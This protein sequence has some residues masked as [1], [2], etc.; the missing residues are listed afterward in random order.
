MMRL[1]ELR[2]ERFGQ[3]TDK[4]F[5]FGDGSRGSDFHIIY[6]P[7]EAGKT[8]TMEA[9]IRLLYGFRHQEP[10]DF[11]HGRS[12]LRVSGV[13]DLAEGPLRL[14]RLPKRAPN[15]LDATGNA[16]PDHA[17][18][19][20]LGGLSE[21]DYRALLCLDDDT[22]ERGG[23]D[24]A[25]AR[26]DIGQLLFSAAAGIADMSD[27][28]TEL[29]ER[30]D[31]LFRKR[32]STTRLAELKR[33]LAEIDGQIR[34]QD[35]SAS[36]W[37]TL[38]DHLSAAVENE[39]SAREERDRLRRELEQA[40]AL[41]RAL[42]WLVEHDRL[43]GEVAPFADYPDQLDIE[44]ESLVQLEKEQAQLEAKRDRLQKEIAT[45]QTELEELH[46]D[47]TKLELGALLDALDEL[48]SRT[49]TAAIDLPKRRRELK[50]V[51][52]E[53]SGCLREL[54]LPP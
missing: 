6:G 26:G 43:V 14:S 3:F 52:D 15:L 53:I 35:V 16:L 45:A 22:I 11:L 23:E 12:N 32:A 38:K 25:N 33:E 19:A 18:G 27:I 13:F 54:G 36:Q 17:V 30:A 44:P 7:N 41:K 48:R 46:P 49:Q 40:R 50:D 51:M 42:P 5:D 31:S 29:R 24:I 39:R 47:Q 8:T 21:E 4:V 1:R 2:L 28:L 9:Y 10:Y 34:E 37:R 20:H